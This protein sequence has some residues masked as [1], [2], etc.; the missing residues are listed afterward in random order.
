[1]DSFWTALPQHFPNLESLT[2]GG[3]V[4]TKPVAIAVYLA[5]QSKHAC[6]PLELLLYTNSVGRQSCQDLQATVSAWQLQNINLHLYPDGDADDGEE[7][8]GSSEEEE[9]SEQGSDD[10]E[11]GSQEGEE[12]E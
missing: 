10:D 1:V 6:K 3:G 7:G 2:V 8:E 9:G 12:E 11:E 4:R 5:M